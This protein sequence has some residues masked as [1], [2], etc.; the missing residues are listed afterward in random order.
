[1]H[2]SPHPVMALRFCPTATHY[3]ACTVALAEIVVHPDG[4][5]PEKC[6][7][8]RVIAPIF[9][10]TIDGKPLVGE[11]SATAAEEG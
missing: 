8:P 4:D 3:V 2:F 10:V 5:Y 1:M 7:A 6:K 11:Q 9:E